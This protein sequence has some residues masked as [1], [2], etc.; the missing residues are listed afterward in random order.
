[1]GERDGITVGALVKVGAVVVGFT[2]GMI[3]E[4]SV[5]LSVE[6][7]SCEIVGSTDVG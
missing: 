7:G 1:M 2:V 5:G 4:N 6:V 3:V